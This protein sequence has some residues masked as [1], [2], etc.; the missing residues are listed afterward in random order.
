MHCLHSRLHLLHPAILTPDR[1][2]LPLLRLLRLLS[3]LLSLLGL[4]RA[5]LRALRA[6]ALRDRFTGERGRKRSRGD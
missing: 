5:L 2:R 3:L 1:S 4:L 6:L